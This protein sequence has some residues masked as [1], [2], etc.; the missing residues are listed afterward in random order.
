MD[1]PLIGIVSR[2][3]YQKGLDL[4]AGIAQSLAEQNVGLVVLGSGEQRFED[5]FRYFAYARP[6]RFGVRIGYDNGLAHRIEAG[7]DMFLM[8]S[9]YEPSGLNQMYSL[10]YG[11]V[12]IVRATGGLA[13]S[14]DDEAGFKFYEYSPAALAAA[15]GVALEAF[16]DR[17]GW[18]ARMRHGMADDFSWDA[19]AAKYQDLYRSL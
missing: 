10:R 18:M 15:I 9:R 4:M 5:M 8:P 6:D 13:D 16:Q 19:S 2:F 3:V 11:T 14:V 17:A 12:P 1:R 7:A